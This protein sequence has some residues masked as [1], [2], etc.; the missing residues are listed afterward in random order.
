MKFLI[1]SWSRNFAVFR[2]R[3]VGI[4]PGAPAWRGFGKCRPAE[5][6]KHRTASRNG[7]E[8]ECAATDLAP[9]PSL[10]SR[11]GTAAVMRACAAV[12]RYDALTARAGVDDGLGPTA[13][14]HDR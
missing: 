14:H 1:D 3:I 2:G 9:D 11:C 8:T 4:Q 6:C 5:R 13:D 7:P 10:P 12:D